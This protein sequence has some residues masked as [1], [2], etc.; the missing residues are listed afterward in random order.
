[1]RAVPLCVWV[2]YIVAPVEGW[3]F[4]PG[5]PLGFLATTALAIVCW[6]AFARRTALPWPG[7]AIALVLKVVLGLSV[8]VPHGFAARYYA[9]ANFAGPIEASTEPADDGVLEDRS[10]AP[11]RHRRSARR[12]AGVLQRPGTLQL[13]SRERP[14]PEH[15]AV[16]GDVAGFLARDVAGA[17]DAVRVVAGGNHPDQRRRQ[18]LR[19]ARTRRTVDRRHNAPARPAPRHDRM[20]RSARRCAPVRGRA[21]PRWPGAAIRR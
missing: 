5:R 12:A 9:N 11:F 18:V 16:F 15:A 6:A 20:V 2:A 17:T 14:R 3:G 1:M 13:L 7:A 4:F 10:S 21:D 19:A 8:L